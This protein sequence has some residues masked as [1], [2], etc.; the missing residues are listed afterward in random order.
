MLR[1]TLRQ[2]AEHSVVP[3]NAMPRVLHHVLQ[4]PFV[5]L[6]YTENVL[7]NKITKHARI[8]DTGKLSPLAEERG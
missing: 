7:Q 3:L 8:V 4:L 1:E 6:V 5:H 2:E